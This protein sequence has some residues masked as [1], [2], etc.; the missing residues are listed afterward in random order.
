ME[1]DSYLL[2]ALFYFNNSVVT[3]AYGP[4]GS[5]VS[6]TA[7][8][9]GAFFREKNLYNIVP[10]IDEENKIISFLSD[11]LF[12][13][14]SISS[15]D[16]GP[17]IFDFNSIIEDDLFFERCSIGL[18]IAK[19]KND[20]ARF[21]WIDQACERLPILPMVAGIP[22]RVNSIGSDE[23]WE[24]LPVEV[25]DD[26]AIEVEQAVQD[27]I[28]EVFKNNGYASTRPEERD[29]VLATLE[30]G[31][32]ALSSR[33]FTLG[34]IVETLRKPLKYLVKKFGDSAIGLAAKKALELVLGL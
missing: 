33:R 26:R 1:K 6:F 17:T 29:T 18:K 15:D 34:T 12:K 5:E 9:I 31:K 3:D 23:D 32:S 7:D 30:A 25:P 14:V 13:S 28:D 16:Y 21:R 10:F 11:D 2:A 20:D 19:L 24:P 8:D 22:K 4:L 27:T